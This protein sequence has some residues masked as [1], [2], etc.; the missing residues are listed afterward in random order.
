MQNITDCHG[1][2]SKG[3]RTGP[4]NDSGDQVEDAADDNL[5]EHG[6]LTGVEEAGVRW[7]ECFFA[8]Y[9][10]LDISNPIRVSL[11]STP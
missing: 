6:L 7:F 10:S 5:P 9:N 1:P 8:R 3:W 2:A 4:E 11:S